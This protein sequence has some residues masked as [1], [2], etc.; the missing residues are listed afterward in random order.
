MEV[1]YRAYIKESRGGHR[2]KYV[3]S[4]FPIEQQLSIAAD[5]RKDASDGKRIR[6]SV[7]AKRELINRALRYLSS[8][9]SEV[10][11]VRKDSQRSISRIIRVYSN[12]VSRRGK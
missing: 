9:A 1:E 12:H 10:S 11:I 3:D 5:R 4:V 8:A 7:P 6:A 2:S